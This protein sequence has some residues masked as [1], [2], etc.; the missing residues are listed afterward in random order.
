MSDFTRRGFLVGCSAAIAS[1]SGSRFNTMSFGAPGSPNDVLIHIFLRGGID[2][3]NLMPPIGGADR[4]HYETARPDLQVPASGDGAALSLGGGF[5]LHPSAASLHELYQDGKLSIVHATGFQNPNRSHFEAMQFIELGSPSNTIPPDG[6]LTRHLA[7]SCVNP[8]SAVMPSV[9]IGTTQQQSLQGSFETINMVNP[10]SFNLN[11]GPFQWRTAQR[12]ALRNIYSNG[13]TFLH[14][15]GLQS[16]DAL[17]VIELNVAGTSSTPSN[18]A[19][20]PSGTFG[21][22]L[23]A[24]ARLIKLDL[25]LQVA[26]IDLGG[27]DTHNAQGNGSTG[28]FAGLLEQ[29]SDALAN[30]YLDLDGSGPNNFTNRVTVVVQ[31]EFGRR[32]RQND[33]DGTDHGHGNMMMVLSG[34]ASGGLHGT[35]PGLSNDQLFDGADLAVTTD[36]R[37]VLSEI[38]IR[39]MGNNNLGVVFPGYQDYSPLGVVSGPDLIPILGDGI[40]DDNFESGDLSAW[41]SSNP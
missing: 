1:Y 3:L 34:N 32:L 22:H 6:W 28:Y 24:V 36:Y 21:D 23:E 2:G 8:D 29:L 31:S 11:T 17:D 37:Q 14:Q 26:T 12:K 30:F 40:F 18:G 13:G 20:Y 16:L 38:L 35:W 25:G 9:A 5:G 41:A 19:V 27:W 15:T 33:D 10:D 4:G 39:R 7:T